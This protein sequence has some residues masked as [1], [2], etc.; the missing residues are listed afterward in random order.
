[1]MVQILWFRMKTFSFEARAHTQYLLTAIRLVLS[2]RR[3]GGNWFAETYTQ[4][5]LRELCI[6][7]LRGM[8]QYHEVT[9]FPSNTVLYTSL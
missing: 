1:M 8:H 2:N 7:R 5:L 3:H 6:T 4:R 9:C